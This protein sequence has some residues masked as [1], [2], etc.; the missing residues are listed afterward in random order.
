MTSRSSRALL[1]GLVVGVCALSSGGVRAADCSP[2]GVVTFICGVISP[3]DLVPVPGTDWVV[4][5]GYEGGGA[6]HLVSTRTHATTQVFPT[7]QPRTRLDARM[8]AACPGPLDP[9]EKEKF[10]AHGLN[11]RAGPNGVHTLYM[12]HHGFRESIEVF[13]VDARPTTPTFTWVGCI[14][15]PDFA[16]FNSVAPLPDGGIVATNPWRRTLTDARARGMAGSPSGEVV[17]WHAASGWTIVPGSESAGPNGVEVSTDGRWLYVTLWPISKVMR[18]SRGQTP[19]QK[20]LIE[21]SFRPDNIRW[22]ADGSL[23]TGGHFAP[24]PEQVMPCLR[25]RCDGVAARVARIDPRTLTAREILSYPSD[26]VFFGGTAAL[27][28]GKEIWIGSVTGDRV[29]RYPIR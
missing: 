24:T 16:A 10:S 22:Q 26:D 7:A 14:P 11:V 20:E 25:K 21:V 29:A 8:Y 5:S 12:V 19:V 2:R 15:A 4:V 9:A 27:Q 1:V 23:L 17:E 13:E 6:L 18:L 3:E 28:V